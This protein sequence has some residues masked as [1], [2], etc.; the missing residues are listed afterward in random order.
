M[1]FAAAS[2]FNPFSFL[3]VQQYLLYLGTAVDRQT[4]L[5]IIIT[6]RKVALRCTKAPTRFNRAIKNTHALLLQSVEVF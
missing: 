3:V 4:A 1:C 2:K 5:T 6:L